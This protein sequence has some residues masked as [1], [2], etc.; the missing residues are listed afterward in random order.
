M[1]LSFIK[2]ILGQRN[3]SADMADDRLALVLSYQ[4]PQIDETR[5]EA[6]ERRLIQL[7]EEFGYD[8]VGEVEVRPQSSDAARTT[9]INANIP[10]KIRGNTGVEN[11]VRR[12]RGLP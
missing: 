2:R 6:F 1:K 8:V 10:V 5:L 11:E 3:R 9:V 7:C 4:R 12:A